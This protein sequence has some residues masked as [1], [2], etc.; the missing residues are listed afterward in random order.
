MKK[1]VGSA[2]TCYTQ[3]AS[4]EAVAITDP[5]NTTNPTYFVHGLDL[6]GRM[7]KTGYGYT[8]NYFLKVEATI[9]IPIKKGRNPVDLSAVARWRR[10]SFGLN[11]DDTQWVAVGGDG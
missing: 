8:G 4:G 9:F 6:I 5:A 1:V 10:E 7:D 2:T 3:G 11:P